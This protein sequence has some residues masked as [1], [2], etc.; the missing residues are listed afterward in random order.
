MRLHLRNAK[1]GFAPRTMRLPPDRIELSPVAA[2]AIVYGLFS[3]ISLLNIK[4]MKHCSV[5]V[6]ISVPTCAVVSFQSTYN[7][8]IKILYVL[9]CGKCCTLIDYIQHSGSELADNIHRIREAGVESG[10]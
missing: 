7:I 2:V 9:F 3:H 6:S 5:S 8:F 4:S 1:Y 10:T